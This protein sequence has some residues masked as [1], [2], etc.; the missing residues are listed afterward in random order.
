MRPFGSVRGRRPGGVR[1]VSRLL[2]GRIARLEAVRK[3]R[4]AGARSDRGSA[5]VWV[6]CLT[7]ALCAV[8]GVLL[9]QGEA[10]LVRHRAAAGADL[11]ALAA[12]DHWTEG[13]ERACSRAARVAG[14]Q[15]GRLV[16]CAVAGEISD[17]TVASGSGLFTAE[18]RARA[19]PA[20]MAEPGAPGEPGAAGAQ[21]LPERIAPRAVTPGILRRTSVL[22][23][24]CALPKA[25]A[26][27]NVPDL[28]KVPDLATVPAKPK[29]PAK[30]GRH[31]P[32]RSL[33]PQA[34]PLPAA[35]LTPSRRG[36]RPR[37]CPPSPRAPH[38]P[39][40]RAPRA[41]AP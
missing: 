11:A 30:P 14:A 4:A 9:A 18:V 22:P 27:P 12:A 32:P 17:V 13:G 37:S 6:V 38:A 34:S 2:G 28:P 31:I 41:A 23:E 7:G 26:L 8:F 1:P 24:A 5:T 40:P 16:R 19:G 39:S 29:V 10:V 21:P 35:C 15:G 25:R 3:F 36:P 20:E 33:T